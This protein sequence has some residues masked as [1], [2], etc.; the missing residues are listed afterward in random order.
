M[1]L[2]SLSAPR[3]AFQAR[4]INDAFAIFLSRE[5]ADEAH[6]RWY[7]RLTADYSACLLLVTLRRARRL[8]GA[9]PVSPH[10][11]NTAL[12]DLLR[13]KEITE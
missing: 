3:P 11:F 5:L 4:S 13:E 6:V 10:H 7:A 12:R 2:S 1:Q 8:A 9:R